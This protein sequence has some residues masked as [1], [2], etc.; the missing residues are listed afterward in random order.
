VFLVGNK[1]YDDII[2][3]AGLSGST[4]AKELSKKHRRVLV[5]EKG[6]REK[7]CGDFKDA[8]RFF[9]TNSIK[10]PIKSKEGVI[11]YRTIMAGGSAFVSAGNLVR[12]LEEEFANLGLDLSSQFAEAEEE[13]QVAPISDR[14]LSSGSRAIAEAARE[15]GI[16][17][18]PMRKAINPKRCIKC[19]KCTLGC[20]TQAKWTPLSYLDEAL[21]HGAE[22]LYGTTV[23]HV[24]EE[25]GAATGVVV[26]SHDGES[27]IEADRIILAAGGL[28][29]PRILLDSGIDDAGSNL[30]IDIFVIVYGLHPE[31]NLMHEPQMSLVC[32]QF[33][34]SK[35]FIVSPHVNQPALLRFIEAGMKGARMN[36][37]NLL[38][39][40]IKIS[41]DGSGT[42][43]AKGMVHKAVSE[44]D[45]RKLDAGIKVAKDILIKTGVQPDSLLVTKPAGAHPG[46]TAA[47]GD[48][49]GVNMETRLPNLYVCDASI[50]PKAPGL[51]PMLTLIALAKKL[52][53]DL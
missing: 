39:L 47:M 36:P 3:G 51:P 42:V 45:Q 53:L 16:S 1:R 7:S 14:L 29:T 46:G 17:M 26:R 31:L 48:V 24:L 4:L 8:V 37:K 27:V 18:L 9:D 23:E 41:D 12:S 38:G 35:G 44:S 13:L 30:Y 40:M 33:H 22:M 10:M 20:K 52:S 28:G 43:E 6:I 19:G 50:I 11:I 15:M 5:I 2:V 21:N 25:H 32:D 34:K 49:V